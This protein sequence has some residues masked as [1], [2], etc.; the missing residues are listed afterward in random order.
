MSKIR[1]E[2]ELIGMMIVFTIIVFT[3]YIGQLLWGIVVL[4][5]LFWLL[6]L[7]DCLQRNTDEFPREGNR[8]KLIWSIVLIFLN[9]AG[10]LL[11]Y[12]LVKIQDNREHDV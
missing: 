4:T 5:T 6:M 9:F 10:A 3:Y 11:Y 12:F 1:T 8:E 7:C 2:W